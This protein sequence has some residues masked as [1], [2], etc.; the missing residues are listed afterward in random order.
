LLYAI[1]RRY[2]V[3]E[4]GIILL[5]ALTHTSSF[6]LSFDYFEETRTLFLSNEFER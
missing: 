1:K 4:K 3:A 2:L 6:K 5:A